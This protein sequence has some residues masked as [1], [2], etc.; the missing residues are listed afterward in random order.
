MQ[1]IAATGEVSLPLVDLS[2]LG[3]PR[4]RAEAHRLAR[5]ESTRP[6]DLSQGPLMRMALLRL[7]EQEHVTLVTMH[8]IITDGW[9]TGLFIS[10][11]TRL[12]GGL[13][14][15]GAA[16]LPELAI[17]YADYA[18][19]QRS[20]LSGPV[21]EA[22][23]AYWRGQL[24]GAP[25]VLELPSDRPRPRTQTFHGAER[26]FA[27]PKRL[28]E[29]LRRLARAE[30]ATLFMLLLAVFKALLCRISG[31]E[32][33]VVGVPIANRIRLETE[34]VIGFFANTLVLR[35][36][37]ADNPEL[38]A[39]LARVREV[40]LGAYAHQEIPF[41]KLVEEIQPERDLAN[42]PLFQV[43]FNLQRVTDQSFQPSGL[44]LEPYPLERDTTKFD[45][46][47]AVTEA[48]A[49]L[50][51][52]LE[53]SRALFDAAT[54]ERWSGYLRR[55]LE[56]AVGDPGARLGDLP[57]LSEGEQAQL[58]REW[59][60]TLAADAAGLSFLARFA[61]QVA[62]RGGESAAR[63]GSRHLSDAELDVRSS[64]LAGWLR[65]EGV[66]VESVV[67]LLLERDLELLTA[68]LGVLKS[69]AAYVPL[70]P[71]HPLARHRQ[72]LGQ[73]GAGVLVTSPSLRGGVAELEGER[74]LGL[75]EVGALL[76]TEPPEAWGGGVPPPAGSL[77]YV[78]FTSGSTG[79]PK[80]AMVAQEG[81]LNHLLAKIS[82]LALGDLDVVAQTASQCFDISVWQF[83]AALLVG[84]RVEV[85]DEETARDPGLLLQA[86]SS[87]G[88]TVLETVPSL[89]RFLLAELDRR[90]GEAPDLSRLRWLIP[91][92]E[93]LA[94]ELCRWWRRHYP[95]IPLLN[96][97]GPTECSDD[98][99]HY[100]LSGEL[101]VGAVRVPIGRPIANL[102][103][104]VL[105]AELREVGIGAT[106]ELCVGGVGVGR[107]Y[108]QDAVRTSLSFV[109]DPHGEAGCRLYRTGDLGR[110]GSRGDLE[111]L[112]RLDHQVKV[113]G[114]RI[115]LEEIE[116]ALRRRPEVE[117]AVV[118]AR[119]DG[120]PEPR[121]VA[122]VVGSGLAP[123]ALRGG[124]QEELPAYMVPAAFVVLPALP[125][126]PN[127][128]VDRRALPPPEE[129]RPDLEEAHV[130]PRN[131]IEQV[132]ADIWS[133]VLAIERVG[134]HDN[135]FDLGG[136]SLLAMQVIFRLRD[137]FQMEVSVR[138]VF[139]SPT[140]AELAQTL[141]AHEPQPG[142]VEKIA[143]VLQRLKQ[144]SLEEVAQ[145]LG[146]ERA[147]GAIR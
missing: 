34:G 112:G 127:G 45:L 131:A 136:H 40:S 61:R 46:S 137:S 3:A 21:L 16:S 66:G 132:V 122:Y 87:R 146:E 65:R 11:I 63:C 60:D 117:S 106:G 35:T 27:L 17:Q 68:I 93:A 49:H 23:M 50:E 71:Q 88:V 114:F 120:S 55:M 100:R 14:G 80:G 85:L 56:G 30:G 22:Q 5:Q 2:A 33:L 105:D 37:L 44:S 47:L 125:L 126:T 84:G 54:V 95:G 79:L 86:V 102:R 103:L 19:W 70:D 29:G 94:P 73:S 140:V 69:G 135:F 89:L 72:V 42:N 41:E 24:A 108:V 76:E 36:V 91:T 115:E 143:T 62:Q 43:M 32:D 52:F 139:M 64:R 124:L 134:V 57:L 81:M 138:N 101:G 104:Y 15:G 97:Y 10:E 12:Y 1:R 96:A 141:V 59:N 121:L 90:G 111:V 116:A 39:L 109:P 28:S 99:T 13:R 9:S 147:R 78:I 128:K 74:S 142:Q 58:L 7:E 82:E 130:P 4:R 113:R 20:W 92:G 75:L 133:E 98:V 38:R 83:L 18:V 26:T 53:Y 144:L 145:L 119:S 31:Q 107:G 48:G 67:A 25:P 129:V 118:L 110:W 123:A 8:H 51:G 6:F 77:A